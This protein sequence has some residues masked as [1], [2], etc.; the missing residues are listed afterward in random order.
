MLRKP[1]GVAPFK[2]HT[3]GFL[4]FVSLHLRL[5]DSYHTWNFRT[6]FIYHT[7]LKIAC[8]MSHLSPKI[9]FTIR[10]FHQWCNARSFITLAMFWFF[11]YFAF[12]Y[13]P[14]FY[15]TSRFYQC[16][17]GK[18]LLGPQP[19]FGTSDFDPW[20]WF[21]SSNFKAEK[22]TSD[23]VWLWELVDVLCLVFRQL[24]WWHRDA[25]SSRPKKWHQNFTHKIYT[26]GKFL[27]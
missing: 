23:R 18:P 26:Q 20:F 27:N 2:N 6:F 14:F 3:W 16:T 8:H 9:I 25:L 4:P 21:P 7:C 19:S 1:I 5:F 11:K 17:S 13:D 10:F 24:F 15:H 22:H 12:W